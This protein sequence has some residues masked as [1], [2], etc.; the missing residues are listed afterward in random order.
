MNFKH[1]YIIF[2][3]LY[4]SYNKLSSS[5]MVQVRHFDWRIENSRISFLAGS[6]PYYIIRTV[7]WTHKFFCFIICYGKMYTF[8]TDDV[9]TLK[10]RQLKK[11]VPSHSWRRLTI[12]FVYFFR[13]WCFLWFCRWTCTCP[14]WSSSTSSTRRRARRPFSAPTSSW[15]R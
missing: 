11:V 8:V 13:L 7:N 1:Y 2:I 3:C 10:F 14:S 4:N 12:N 9:M 5:S 6:E 15:P